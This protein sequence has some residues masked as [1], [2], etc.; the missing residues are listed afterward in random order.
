MTTGSEGTRVGYNNTNVAGSH[1]GVSASAGTNAAGQTEL[2]A[3]MRYDDGV[4]KTQLDYLM[5]QGRRSLNLSA[6]ANTPNGLRLSAAL[7]L[8]ETRLAELALKMGYQDPT[9]FRGFLLGYKRKWVTDGDNAGYVDHFDALLE[10][11]FG[12]WYARLSGG[13]DM[14]VAGQRVTRAN[15]DVSAGYQLTP[16]WMVVGGAQMNGARKEDTEQFRA[17]PS[18]PSTRR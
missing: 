17:R 6:S 7:R 4:L 5:R 11:A 8:D 13:L 10:Y 12:R 16:S 2:R 1:V 3:G 9:Q 18:S 15:A 14:A